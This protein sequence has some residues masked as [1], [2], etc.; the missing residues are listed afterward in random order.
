MQLIK[1]SNISGEIM[2]L[3]EEADQKVILVSPYCRLSKWYKFRN[4]LHDLQERKIAVEFYVREGEWETIK[5]IEDLNFQ[6]I[7]IPYLHCKLYLNEKYGIVSSMNLLLSSE[8][9]ALEIGYKTESEKEYQELVDFYD[10]YISKYNKSRIESTENWEQK[11]YDGLCTAF[12]RRI[13]LN[14]ND[15]KIHLNTNQNN[16]EAFIAYDRRKYILR[17]N[18]ILSQSEYKLAKSNQHKLEI[19]TGCPVEIYDC[20]QTGGYHMIWGTGEQALQSTFINKPKANEVN[21]IIDFIIRF[22][23]EIDEFKLGCRG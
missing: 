18:G 9:N 23:V 14:I 21:F 1:P 4:K 16:Y 12:Q 8:N 17:M 10:R 5:E 7:E 2:T 3:I 22:A 13:Q 15:N 20:Y 6:P 19:A 11:L